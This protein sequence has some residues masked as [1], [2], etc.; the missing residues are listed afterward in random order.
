MDSIE[1]LGVRVDDANYGDLLERVD[2]FVASGRPHH[3]VTLNPEM[4][5]AARDDPAFRRVRT[6]L[7]LRIGGLLSVH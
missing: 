3:I 5:V 6:E 2:A 7:R 4:L 1:I